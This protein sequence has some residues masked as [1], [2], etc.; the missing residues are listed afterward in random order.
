VAKARQEAAEIIAGASA[1][2]EHLRP[3]TQDTP[4]TT[5]FIPAQSMPIEPPSASTEHSSS[6]DPE[7]PAADTKPEA[8]PFEAPAKGTTTDSPSVADIAADTPA[9]DAPAL[10]AEVHPTEVEP[11]AAEPSEA[12]PTEVT[13]PVVAEVGA[14]VSAEEPSGEIRRVTASAHL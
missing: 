12:Q 2:A 3:S 13:P 1:E 7:P 8:D 4:A 5:S 9:A 14:D 10:S 6:T 11:S